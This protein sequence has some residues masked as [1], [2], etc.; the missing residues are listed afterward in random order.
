M[1]LVTIPGQS[2]GGPAWVGLTPPAVNNMLHVPVYGVLAWLWF[3]SLAAYGKSH[4][5]ALW[6]AV[7]IS[8]IYGVLNEVVQIAV[9][10]RYA[11]LTDILLNLAGV[12]ICVI[13]LRK[14]FASHS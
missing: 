14:N 6:Y 12:A 11:S 4:Q 10:G 13:I 5:A 2:A 3:R 9:P 8:G 1:T 7:V